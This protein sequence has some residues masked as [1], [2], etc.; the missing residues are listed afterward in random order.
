MARRDP[1]MLPCTGGENEGE[2]R[3]TNTRMADVNLLT[4]NSVSNG[5]MP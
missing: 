5:E 1:D 4:R 2:F 3:R